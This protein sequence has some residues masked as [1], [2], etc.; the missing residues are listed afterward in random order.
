MKLM[1]EPT[2]RGELESGSTDRNGRDKHTV[3][4]YFRTDDDLEH[5]YPMAINGAF[6][7]SH[8]KEPDAGEGKWPGLTCNTVNEWILRNA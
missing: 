1:A 2:N 4:H 8:P 6:G 3:C 7:E 5:L